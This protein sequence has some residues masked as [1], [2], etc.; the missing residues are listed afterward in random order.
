MGFLLGR[1]LYINLKALKRADPLGSSGQLLQVALKMNS[2]QKGFS[3]SPFSNDTV[4][5]VF[6]GSIL[7]KVRRVSNE[8]GERTSRLRFSDVNEYNCIDGDQSSLSKRVKVRPI[9]SEPAFSSDDEF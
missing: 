5:V 8:N 2:K 4:V 6:L 1:T 3:P 9:Y 7:K